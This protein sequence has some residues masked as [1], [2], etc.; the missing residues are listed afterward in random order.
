M[1]E[2]RPKVVHIAGADNDASDA[3][4]RLDLTDK[5]DDLRVWEQKQKQLEY[6][7]VQMMNLCMFMSESIFEEDGFDLNSNILMALSDSVKSSY[8]LDLQSMR[9]AQLKN[10]TLMKM[11]ENHI[12]ISGARSVYTYKSVEGIELIHKNNR[13]IVP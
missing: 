7:D 2:Y 13:I 10:E 4:S 12:V 1:K 5:A 3:L 6:I 8:A 11:V 9:T